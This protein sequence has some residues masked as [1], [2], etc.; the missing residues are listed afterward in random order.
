MK[1]RVDSG[2]P[3]VATARAQTLMLLDVIE[4]CHDQRGVDLFETQG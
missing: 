2:Q 1:E 4:K 3:Q